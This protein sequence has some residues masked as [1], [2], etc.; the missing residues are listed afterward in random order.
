MTEVAESSS[1]SR[2]EKKFMARP[3]MQ[4]TPSVTR[5]SVGNSIEGSAAIS[6]E[7]AAMNRMSGAA[8]AF[9]NE[10]EPSVFRGVGFDRVQRLCR[11]R[12]L[13]LWKSLLS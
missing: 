13:G 4:D 8:S 3:A 12:G 2:H 9:C 11:V 5:P 1:L 6:P 7:P 10:L